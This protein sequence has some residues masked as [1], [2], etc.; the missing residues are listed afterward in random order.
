MWDWQHDDEG[1]VVY[2]ELEM[3]P[4]K[5]PRVVTQDVPETEYGT[6]VSA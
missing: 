3:P 4:A 6:V 5:P 2:A 1:G